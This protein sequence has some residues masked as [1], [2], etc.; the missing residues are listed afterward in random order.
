MSSNSVSYNNGRQVQVNTNLA[1]LF[2]FGSENRQVYQYTNS[3]YDPVTLQAGTVMGV[4]A[5]TGYVTPMTSGAADGS[6]YPIGI[7]ADDYTID[8]GNTMNLSIMTKGQV[9][10]DMI[11][12]QGSDTLSTV[13]SGRRIFERIAS[14]SCGIYIVG[15]ANL[16]TYDNSL[17]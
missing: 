17:S 6:Q 11:L 1:K 4:I 3:T 15:V 13:V 7:L 9:R 8:E 10:A 12:L 16:T 14:D 5:A 2:P